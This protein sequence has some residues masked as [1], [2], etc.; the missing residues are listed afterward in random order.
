MWMTLLGGVL[1]RPWIIALVVMGVAMGGMW[2]NINVLKGDIV[3]LRADIVRVESNFKT[4][5]VNENT[6]LVSI[7][8]QNGSIDS[9]NTIIV[10]LQDQVKAEQ[11]TAVTWERKYKNRPV[12]TKIKEVPV[13]QYVEK[14]VVV[15][16][17][18]SKE[19]IDYFN[20]LF[21]D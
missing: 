21:G 17:E 6:L 4:C 5:K 18:T 7:E 20:I 14:G 16:E 1:K 3:D 10:G 2:I 19:Y 8:E 11:K 15:D 13:I 9:L 12:I